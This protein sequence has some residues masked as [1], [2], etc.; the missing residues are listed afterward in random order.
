MAI[1]I[2]IYIDC[3][4]LK[5]HNMFAVEL[6]RVTLFKEFKDIAFYLIL[7]CIEQKWPLL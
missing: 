3:W 4:P 1:H 7:F 6:Y 2:S 5:P